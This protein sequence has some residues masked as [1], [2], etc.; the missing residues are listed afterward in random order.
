M[1]FRYINDIAFEEISYVA[2]MLANFLVKS[3]H[4]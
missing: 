3:D 4:K 2:E 1:G